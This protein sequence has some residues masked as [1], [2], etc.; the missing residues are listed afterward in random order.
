[1]EIDP[2][3]VKEVDVLPSYSNVSDPIIR[4]PES[5]KPEVL[6]TFIE[7]VLPE[8]IAPVSYTHLTAA[9]DQ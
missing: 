7:V 4:V 8:D 9:D 2:E 3:A 1:M 5:G 6:S